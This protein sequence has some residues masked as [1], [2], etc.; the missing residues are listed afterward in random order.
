MNTG[1]KEEILYSCAECN[2]TFMEYT[3]SA[4]NCPYCKSIRIDRYLTPKQKK[5]QDQEKIK[6]FEDSIRYLK[7]FSG[8]ADIQQAAVAIADIALEILKT[9]KESK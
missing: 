8:Y 7:D 4:F 5:K 3:Y 6:D 1:T 2:K 9:L